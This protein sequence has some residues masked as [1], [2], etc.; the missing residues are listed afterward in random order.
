M[1]GL[2]FLATLLLSFAAAA[3][4]ERDPALQ[5]SL[6][7]QCKARYET[8]LLSP[9]P[10][11][12]AVS[13]D[14]GRC[15]YSAGGTSADKVNETALRGCGNNCQI[16]TK[17]PELKP[18]EELTPAEMRPAMRDP[19]SRHR[20]PQESVGAVIWSPGSTPNTSPSRNST[21][22]FVRTFN[23][24]KWDVWRVDRTGPGQNTLKGA[25]DVL[26]QAVDRVKAAGYRKIVLAGQSA[27]GFISLILGAR[28]ND[29]DAAIATAPAV[30]GDLTDKKPEE[31]QRVLREFDAIFSVRIN[32]NTRMAVALFDKD[33]FEP[34]ANQRVTILQRRARSQ[35]WP[36]L[37][38]D[39]PEGL[40]GHDVGRGV[41]FALRYR[42]C[43]LRFVELPTLEG[44]IHD[45]P[46]IMRAPR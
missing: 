13:A 34:S 29:I 25:M 3:Q 5:S 22:A 44:G 20:G 28:R 33:Q 21:A 35:G 24:A 6:G 32:P 31:L 26:N 27:G 40:A 39:Q 8:Y 2:A 19:T 11:A 16:I 37:L 1:K 38:I 9:Y 10:R 30:R 23:E 45:C 41:P 12:F 46:A 36:I 15:G 7:E 4:E 17:S 18:D 14:K 42:D 43:L